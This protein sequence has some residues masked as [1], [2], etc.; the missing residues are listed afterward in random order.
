MLIRVS[1]VS[2]LDVSNHVNLFEIEIIVGKIF[3]DVDQIEMV[4]SKMLREWRT[5]SLEYPA[6]RRIDRV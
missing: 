6:Y 2:K 5:N 4:R 3:D 1:A